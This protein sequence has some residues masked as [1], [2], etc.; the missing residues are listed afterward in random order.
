MERLSDSEED[1]FFSF[2]NGRH[3]SFSWIASV[4][5]SVRVTLGWRIPISNLMTPY[6]LNNLAMSGKILLWSKDGVRT[7]SFRK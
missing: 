1:D 4:I 5:P 3:Q 6:F 2:G 7:S